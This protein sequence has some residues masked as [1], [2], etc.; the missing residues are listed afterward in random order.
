MVLYERRR[1]IMFECRI[2]VNC[3]MRPSD[4]VRVDGKA[5]IEGVEDLKCRVEALTKQIRMCRFRK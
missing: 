4:V 5:E 3:P 2:Y 1:T